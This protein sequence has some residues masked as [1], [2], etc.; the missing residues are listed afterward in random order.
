MQTKDVSFVF[1]CV[2]DGDGV[3]PANVKQGSW[4][5]E[6]KKKRRDGMG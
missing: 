4:L 1:S 2:Q 5:S 3:V 6:G